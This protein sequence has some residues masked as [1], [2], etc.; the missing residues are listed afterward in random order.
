VPSAVFRGSI[1]FGDFWCHRRVKVSKCVASISIL[2]EQI[3]AFELF[4][5][6]VTN[7]NVICH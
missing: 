1:E 3:F 6:I 5:V 2:N 4:C 7:I